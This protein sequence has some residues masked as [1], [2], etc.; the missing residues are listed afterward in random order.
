MTSWKRLW[1]K[2]TKKS[3]RKVEQRYDQWLDDL[4]EQ[5]GS[6]ERAAS[7]SREIK[8]NKRNET[9]DYKLNNSEH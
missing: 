3:Q 7:A 8:K 4:Q 5:Y 9:P 1:G 6:V 2:K